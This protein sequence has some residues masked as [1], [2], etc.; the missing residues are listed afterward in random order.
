MMPTTETGTKT[1]AQTANAGTIYLPKQP[2]P[3][4]ML[5]PS[6]KITRNAYR[7]A[8]EYIDETIRQKGVVESYMYGFRRLDDPEHIIRDVYFPLQLCSPEG[9]EV[10]E[11]N[12]SRVFL[13]FKT[14]KNY[15]LNSWIHHH[16]YGDL[17]PSG[18]SFPPVND[19]D[20]SSGILDNI[21]SSNYKSHQK[22]IGS[23]IDD[24]I[25]ES[26]PD[27][28]IV[29]RPDKEDEGFGIVLSLKSDKIKLKD[30]K[31]FREA[32]KKFLS[33]AGTTYHV[34][35]SYVHCIIMNPSIQ[36]PSTT[37]SKIKSAAKKAIEVVDSTLEAI[38][39]VVYGN[40]IKI[41]DEKAKKLQPDVF[42]DPYAGIFYK[43]WTSFNSSSGYV[44]REQLP[45]EIVDVDD[46]IRV[47]LDRIAN[48][49]EKKA[50]KSKTRNTP[51]LREFIDDL[52]IDED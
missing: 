19:I 52:L 23:D 46:D 32:V 51:F 36:P 4:E 41:M 11:Q 44:R 33:F 17:R 3:F 12:L 43:T 26:L 39:N 22:I 50:I 5:F 9:V 34:N 1:D 10:D 37:R 25:I 20:G 47:R 42:K 2:S 48:N 31:Q 7:K 21:S 45:L 40:I 15:I 13:N 35:Y 30:S 6:V 49:V 24:M 8:Q 28:R 18:P 16:C 27:G 29:L 38:E 14:K